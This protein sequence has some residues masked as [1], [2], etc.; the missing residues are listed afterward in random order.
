[1]NFWEGLLV[2]HKTNNPFYEKKK[3]QADPVF[4]KKGF[5]QD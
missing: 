4:Y 2:I 3:Q 5:T 1:M